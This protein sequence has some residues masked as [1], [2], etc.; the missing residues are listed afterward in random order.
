MCFIDKRKR[1]WIQKEDRVPDRVQPPGRVGSGTATQTVTFRVVH[2][3]S[4]LFKQSLLGLVQ[5]KEKL[6]N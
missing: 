2:R 3:K 4:I 1:N 6:N 5:V